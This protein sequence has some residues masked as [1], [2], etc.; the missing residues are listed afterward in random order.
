MVNVVVYILSDDPTSSKVQKLKKL[1]G[2]PMFIVNA[3]SPT[4]QDSR[5][6]LDCEYNRCVAALND[7]HHNSSTDYTIIVKDSSISMASPEL[8]ADVI[9]TTINSGDFDIC[10]LCKWADRCDLY[11]N[12]IPINNTSALIVKTQSGSG[13]QALLFAPS[14]RV[15]I[16]RNKPMKNG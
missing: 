13:V 6:E 12:K 14:G 8:M 3:L 2:H 7:S 16:L 11:T 5:S 10:Y 15:I 1:F 9:N 4:C